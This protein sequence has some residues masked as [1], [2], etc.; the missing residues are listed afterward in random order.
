[1]IFAFIRSLVEEEPLGKTPDGQFL[2]DKWTTVQTT[3]SSDAT[4]YKA[5]K[6]H[7]P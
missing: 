1:M 3:Q 6:G 5:Y 7:R 4:N 2:N